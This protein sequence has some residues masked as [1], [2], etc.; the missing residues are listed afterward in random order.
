MNDTILVA[1]GATIDEITIHCGDFP[2]TLR[3]LVEQQ[4][5]LD[6]ECFI[7]MIHQAQEHLL[8]IPNWRDRIAETLVL[9]RED[10]RVSALSDTEWG[11]ALFAVVKLLAE[12]SL[13]ADDDVLAKAYANMGVIQDRSMFIT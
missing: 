5:S 11:T 2:C 4:D 12:D 9:R 8:Y 1:S 10:W 6:V 3:K 7:R 13:S